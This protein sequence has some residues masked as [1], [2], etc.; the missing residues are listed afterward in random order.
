[1]PQP[2]L[3]ATAAGLLLALGCAV[4]AGIAV[5]RFLSDRPTARRA[6]QAI[7]AGG[8]T[9]QVIH[10]LEHV[11]QL[12]FWALEPTSKPWLSSW[13]A[14]TADGL[15]YFCSL[16]P[17]AGEEA[18]IGVE[19]LHLTGNVVFLGALTAW[20]VAM[21]SEQRTIRTLG[22]AEKVQL[23]HVAEHVVLVGSLLAFG[24]A[25]GLSTAFGAVDGTALVALRVWFHFSINAVAT[26]YALRA[27]KETWGKP[28]V[29]PPLT[30]VELTA[31][32]APDPRPRTVIV[33]P[34]EAEASLQER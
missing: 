26:T 34:D 30:L 5:Y 29:I 20:Q 23:F 16:L 22:I 14:G 24:K 12:S 33:L 9:F 32:P 31:M 27:A 11:L 17:A 2:P 15:Q 10:V 1:M 8:L 4:A 6:M 3:P 13:A 7:A 19:M 28:K 25:L 21:R 18:S